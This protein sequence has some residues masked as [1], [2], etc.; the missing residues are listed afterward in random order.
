VTGTDIMAA[1]SAF[2][3][4]AHGPWYTKLERTSL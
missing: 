3:L 2:L 1:S 4:L